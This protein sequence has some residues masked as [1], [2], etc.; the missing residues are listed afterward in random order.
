MVQINQPV[1]PNVPDAYIFNIPPT[2]LVIGDV[3]TDMIGFVGTAIWGPPNTPV[4]FS[5]PKSYAAIFGQSQIRKYDMGRQ[6]FAACLTGATNH[7]GVRVTDGTDVAATVVAQT[8]CITFTSKCTGSG[9]NLDTVSTSPGSAV[10]SFK[11]IVNR[12]N[13][14][15]EVFDNLAVGLTGNAVWVAIAAAINAG[16]NALRGASNLVVAT[17]GAGTATP[18][19]ASYTLTGGTDGATTITG[20]V[21]VG[22]DTGTRKGMYALRATGPGKLVLADNDD[23]TT[24]AA[25]V[26][27]CLQEGFYGMLTGPSGEYVNLATVAANKA[28]AG[29]D[30]YAVKVLVGDWIW[31]Q[32]PS[33]GVLQLVSP[34]GFAAGIL[35]VGGPQNSGLNKPI[36][37]IV[38]TQK[39]TPLLG[40]GQV[41]DTA[42]IS[43][44][45]AGQLDVI[46]NP[47]PA[48]AA[49]GLRQGRN[50]SSNVAINGDN[51]SQMIPYLN[52][53]AATTIGQFVGM[54]QTID[55]RQDA[56]DTFDAWLYDEW[57]NK[58]TISNPQGTQPYSVQIN[59]TN[60]PA[61][62]PQLGVEVANLKI[63]LGPV[64]INF[65]LNIEAGQTVTVAS[66]FQLAA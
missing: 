61:P 49:F 26:S 19:T 32:D 21:L 58:K 2:G 8:N 59:D 39:T 34:Q 23:S 37:G 48:G 24:W 1:N 64:I 16:T 22:L 3:Q 33:S 57:K 60:N 40:S 7:R 53:R 15:P 30:T 55:Q 31:F 66:T 36:N 6:V 42:D 12:P 29:I 13:L 4:P 46:T 50:T 10:G 14:S 20:A 25:Q 52:A 9:A 62:G 45:G 28:A 56:T 54:L 11:A 27:F 17:A 41:Y 63:Q 44:I 5:D 65:V 47:I 43:V 35:A 18:A 51:Y 38:G